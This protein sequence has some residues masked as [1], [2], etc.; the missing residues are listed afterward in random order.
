MRQF[1]LRVDFLA[2]AL[3]SINGRDNF[4]DAYPFGMVF[5]PRIIPGG[6]KY[7][8]SSARIPGPD[9]IPLSYLI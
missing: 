1:A 6:I 9:E 4:T 7:S 3:K 8:I 2:Q 5:R